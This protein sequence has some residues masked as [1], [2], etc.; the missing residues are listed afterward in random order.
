[1]PHQP[2]INL[3]EKSIEEKKMAKTTNNKID[4]MSFFINLNVLNEIE[5]KNKFIECLM[6]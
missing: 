5:T 2:L 6:L 3:K 4:Y 1:M